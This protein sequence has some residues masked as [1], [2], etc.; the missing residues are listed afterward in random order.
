MKP[1]FVQTPTMQDLRALS[2][3]LQ[4]YC[5]IKT[6]HQ[7]CLTPHAK[8]IALACINTMPR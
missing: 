4:C 7:A 3:P 2:L 8:L 6:Y 5:A 1:T